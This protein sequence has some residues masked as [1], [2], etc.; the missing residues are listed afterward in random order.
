MRRSEGSISQ[1]DLLGLGQDGDGAGGGMN[2]PLGLGF[3]NPLHPVGAA[4]VL[5]PRIDLVAADQGDDFLEAAA[6][7][8]GGAHDLHPP[9]LAVGIAGI[10]AKEVGGEQGRLLA[11]GAGADLRG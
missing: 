6:V 2:A 9:A 1:V 8:F 4:F 10:H 3:R 7:R 11:A 5:Q